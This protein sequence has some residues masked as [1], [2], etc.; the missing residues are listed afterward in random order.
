MRGRGRPLLKPT[1]M[2]LPWT[3]AFDERDDSAIY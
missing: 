1:S 2:Y 3:F